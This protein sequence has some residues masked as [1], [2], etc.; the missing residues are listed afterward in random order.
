MAKPSKTVIMTGGNSGLGY[1]ASRTILQTSDEYHVV[2]AGRSLERCSAAVR[3]LVHEIGNPHVEAVQ[4]DLGS[5]AAIRDFAS[6]FFTETR[7]PLRALVCNAGVQHVGATQRT[8]DGFEATFGVNHLGHFLLANLL[9]ERLVAPGR[10]VFVASGTHDPQQRTGM[11]APLLRD[12]R[13]LASPQSD[14]EAPGSP[15]F[16]GRRRYTTSKLCN[17]L[18]AYE[19][20][21]RLRAA[22]TSTPELPITV[23]AFDPGAMPGTGLARDYGPMA[24]WAWNSVGTLL[25]WAL[26]PFHGN[27]HFPEES[28]RALARLVLDPVL[29]NVSGRY[30]EG[31]RDVRSSS[32]SYDASKAAALWDQSAELVGLGR[33]RDFASLNTAVPG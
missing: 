14:D 33:E 4:L 16:L 30:F 2:I 8:E 5:L 3:Q 15:G 17:V 6:D 20:D 10:I 24:Q 22:G 18:C 31:M 26:R 27:F 23:N 25:S 1:H 19:M 12:A 13:S 11:P 29:E 32:E 7:P 21:R 28:G 9:V